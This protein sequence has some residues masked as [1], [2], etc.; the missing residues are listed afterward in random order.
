VINPD[1]EKIRPPP[2]CESPDFRF[3]A[4]MSGAILAPEDRAHL[5]R[6]MRQQTPS[7]VHRRMNALLL[8]DDGWTAERI[9]EVLFIDA[10]TVREHRRLYRTAGVT[11]LERLRY[12]GG[13]PALTAEQLTALGAELDARLHMTAKAVC[14]FVERSFGVSYTAHAMAKL[15]KRLNFVYKKPKRVPAKA[16]EEIQRRFFEATLGPLMTAASDDQPL[17]FV[18]GTHPSYTAHA[19]YGWIR[20]GQTRELKSNHGRTNINING[21][22]SW[23][24]REFVHRQTTGRITSA[25]M[26]L[27]LEDLQTRHPAATAIR[28]VLDNASYNHSKEIKAW[29]G[30]DDCRVKPVYLPAYAPNLNLIERFWWLFKKTAIYNAYFPTFAEFKA[31][32]EGFFARLD[33]Y[34]SEL[35]SLITDKFHFI[36]KFNPQAP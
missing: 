1:S 12:E 5:L 2:L 13:E 27:L 25:E 4:A 23:P 21:A 9:A 3:A 11:G 8:L 7:P 22:L 10:D 33:D 34:R 14:A 35:A 20:K 31:A 24:G 28:V 32:V 19:A 16:D 17:Y 26:I 15:L 6:M 29:L 36:G 30:C 18:D